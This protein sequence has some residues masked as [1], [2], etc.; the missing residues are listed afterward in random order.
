MAEGESVQT[1]EEAVS[2]AFLQAW[3]AM[4]SQWGINRTMAQIHAYLLLA[5]EGKSTDDVMAALDISRGNAHANL[6]ELRQW[7][8]LHSRHRKG[9]RKE[10]FEAEK[11]VWTIFTRILRERHKREV[12]PALRV[13]ES[14]R[15]Q[16]R[17]LDSDEGRHLHAQISELAEFLA[18][19]SAALSRIG[20]MKRNAF[21]DLVLKRLS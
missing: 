5:P 10:Y 16:S 9:D 4:G 1:S 3:G 21:V 14:C 19:T 15:D 13:L 18:A 12:E 7:G 2:D 6:K 20:D 17:G 8:L 11:D